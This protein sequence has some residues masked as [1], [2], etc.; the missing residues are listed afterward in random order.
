MKQIGLLFSGMLLMGT[1]SWDRE[2]RSGV[3]VVSDRLDLSL[4]PGTFILEGYVR[5]SEN[6]GGISRATVKILHQDT[7]VL[8]DASGKFQLPATIRTDSVFEFYKDGM[9]L[10]QLENYHFLDQHRIAVNAYLCDESNQMIKRKPVIYCYSDK[11]VDATIRLDPKGHFTFTYPAYQNGWEIQV[12]AAGGVTDRKT[13][14][15]YPYLFWEAASEP[16]QYQMTEQG[17][18]GFVIATDTAVQFLESQLSAMGLNRVEQTDF[19]TFWVPVLQRKPF[20]LVQF[21]MEASYQN[22]VAEWI[23]TPSPDAFRRVFMLFS[24]LE[25]P[26]LGT[27]VIPQKFNSF[28]R[29]GFTVVEWGGSELDFLSDKPN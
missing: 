2:S 23:I 28:E 16:L 12:N 26:A 17:L 22:Q 1:L 6:N 7:G 13:G 3:E 21:L 27:P 9:N 15:K 11:E 24:P 29:N 14:K 18:P 10:V 25:E 5:N 20:A 19:I 4:E 8:T